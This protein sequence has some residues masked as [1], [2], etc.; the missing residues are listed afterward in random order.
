VQSEGSE[1]VSIRAPISPDVRRA[2]DRVIRSRDAGPPPREVAVAE[3]LAREI[4][5]TREF[6]ALLIARAEQGGGREESDAL[7][8]HAVQLRALADEVRA[9]VAGRAARETEIGRARMRV[10]QLAHELDLI[11]ES[12]LDRRA[13]RAAELLAR[14]RRDDTGG[15]DAPPPEPPPMYLYWPAVGEPQ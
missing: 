11:A 12:K 5:Q 10:R 1:R 14:L 6:L 7:Q 3:S 8:A 15:V 9:T 2:A 4:L 13:D